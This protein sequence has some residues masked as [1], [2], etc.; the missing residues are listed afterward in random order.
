M[1]PS[2]LTVVRSYS[3][4]SPGDFA[5]APTANCGPLKVRPDYRIKSREFAPQ[6][7][8]SWCKPSV[9]AST[10]SRS[11]APQV[12]IPNECWWIGIILRQA[13]G[14]KIPSWAT[15]ITALWIVPLLVC[16]PSI[17]AADQPDW[18]L[19]LKGVSPREIVSE[20]TPPSSPFGSGHRG[21]DFPATQGQR[22]AAVGSGIVSFAGSIA[23]K[24]VV[25]IEL[26]QSVDGLGT[27]VRSTY[28]PVTPLVRTGDFVTAGTIIGFIDFASGNSGHCKNTCL[29]F[30]LKVMGEPAARYL[31][32]R[33]LWRWVASLRP[34][35]VWFRSPSEG[36]QFQ[37]SF[38][39]FQR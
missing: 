16:V 37:K 20:F 14:M 35:S 11:R 7:T 17:A 30:G 31:N 25:S 27:R 15:L 9:R 39:A 6:I 18:V 36:G 5:L 3:S 26:S 4:N 10:G 32:P 13:Q 8:H 19:P 21:V 2:P 38:G 12:T 29:H 28:E 24:P 23:G 34:S 33:N 22:V 1:R